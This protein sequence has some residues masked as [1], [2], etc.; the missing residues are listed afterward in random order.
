MLK[1]SLS[2]ERMH[3]LN[4]SIKT[5]ENDCTTFEISSIM[6]NFYFAYNQ[7]VFLTLMVRDERK[8]LHLAI[9]GYCYVFFLLTF[10]HFFNE[11]F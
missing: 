6:E 5:N 8:Q 11:H 7:Q 2:L 9:R 10:R 4:N 1:I 3:R